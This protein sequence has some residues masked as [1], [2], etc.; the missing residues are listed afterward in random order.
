MLQST[1]AIIIGALPSPFVRKVLAICELK[2]VPYEIDPVIPFYAN[3]TFSKMSPLRRIPVFR[4]D[5]VTLADS[6]VICQYLEDRYPEP[7]AYPTNIAD[8]AEARWLEE[9]AD[10]R[11]ADVC[12]WRIFYPAVVKPHVFGAVRDLE[13]VGKVVRGELPDI[14]AYLEAKAPTQG[15][16]FGDISI[17]D[18]SIAVHMRNL[19]WARVEP[20]I[21]LAPK[22]F[23]WLSRVENHPVLAR[24]TSIADK[25]V[26]TPP[27]EQRAL[28]ASM[29]LSVTVDTVA[30]TTARHGP[31]T[32]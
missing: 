13:G 23:A 3:E 6:S 26:R 14:L 19:R 8:R 7:P 28:I 10:S 9:F 31:M 11:M 16:L 30:T 5:K 18:I 2:G 20:D 25:A 29:G 24:L 12:I 27:G 17:A 21:G 15:F 1:K 22:A 32:V 4:D